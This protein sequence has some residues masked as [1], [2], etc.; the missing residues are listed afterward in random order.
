VALTLTTAALNALSGSAKEPNI[1][2]K[3]DGVSTIFGSQKVNAYSSTGELVEIS[4]QD[5]IITLD[6]TSTSIKQTLNVDK[7]EGSTISTVAIA[8]MDD[9][10]ATRLITPG[11][12][13]DD[14]LM[15]QAKVYLGFNQTGFPDD[16]VTI[17][18]GIITDI[19]ADPGKIVL[20][21]NHADDKKRTN[22]FKASETKLTAEIDATTA[23][24]PVESTATF[25]RKKDYPPGVYDLSFESYFRIDDEIIRYDSIDS[26]GN[27]TGVV[28]GAY[29][30]LAASHSSGTTVTAQYRLFGNGIDLAL[31]IMASGSSETPSAAVIGPQNSHKDLP[32]TSINVGDAERYDNALYFKGVNISEEYGLVAGDWLDVLSGSTHL[33]NQVTYK[34]IA[35]IIEGA[36]GD[37]VLIEDVSFVDDTSSGIKASF[38]S[39]YATLPDG[40]RLRPDEIDV[41]EHLRLYRLFLNSVEYD[42]FLKEGIE[43]AKEWLEKQIYA[44]MSCFSLPRKARAS[45]GYHIGPIPGQDIV[46]FDK[47]NI[48]SP[49]Q[50]R[51]KRSSN[52]NFFNEIVFK[53]DEDRLE[54]K[55]LTGYITI[56]ADSKNRIKNAPNRTLTLEAKGMRT[57]LSADNI[58]LIQGRRR[59]KRYE[60]GAESIS[61]DSLLSSAFAVE[62]GDIILFDGSELYLPDTKTGKKGLA[63][64]FFEIVNKDLQLKTGDVRFEAIDTN[65]SGSAKYGLIGPASKIKSGISST[66]FVIEESYGSRFGSSEYLKWVGLKK[67]SV[68]IRNADFSIVGD[69][70]IQSFTSNTVTV[71]PA[72]AFEP[73]VGMIMELTKYDDPDVTEQVKMIYVHLK[74]TDFDDGKKQFQLL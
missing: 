62:I 11:E 51:L 44:P 61:F 23:T 29:G 30:T 59:I 16:Y 26:L 31:K 33:E 17:F 54:D 1:V 41:F 48:K 53:Y 27:F 42:F 65:F 4:D 7:A 39:Q 22:I 60:F 20:Q 73:S 69:T 3:I 66:K 25:L 2:L 67:C 34:K 70:V 58:A 43:E 19:T 68:R 64:R 21:L 12:I 50:L 5:N 56:S 45:V 32:V 35:E 28:R 18:R 9:G 8:L 10:Y 40:C 37:F 74:N 52:K 14:L 49:S 24:I 6:G 71:S 46:T 55:F 36:Q 63:P 57:E 47:S 15:R 72:L 38:V 13:V